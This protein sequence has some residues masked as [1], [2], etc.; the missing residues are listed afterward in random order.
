MDELEDDLLEA[1]ARDGLVVGLEGYRVSLKDRGFDVRVY[2]HRVSVL[3][4]DHSPDLFN[5]AVCTL[6]H[7]DPLRWSDGEVVQRFQTSE[8]VKRIVEFVAEADW[9]SEPLSVLDA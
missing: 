2:E 8:Q 4:E 6:Q 1:T 5:V 7:G 9:L 3:V